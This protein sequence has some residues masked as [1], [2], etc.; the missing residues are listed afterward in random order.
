MSVNGMATGKILWTLAGGKHVFATDGAIVL[1]LV[2]EAIVRCKDCNA[3][4]HGALFAV[5]K[6]LLTANATKA[7]VFAMK[8]FFRLGHPQVANA[9]VILAKGRSTVNTLVS[10]IVTKQR[11]KECEYVYNGQERKSVL[12]IHTQSYKALTMSVDECCNACKRLLGP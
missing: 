5:T 10:I 6:I 3:N 12:S 4:A 9:A 1:V 2:L 7:T 11:K 8:G